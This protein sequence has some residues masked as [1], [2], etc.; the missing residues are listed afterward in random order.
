MTSRADML[1]TVLLISDVAVYSETLA[2]KINQPKPVFAAEEK[3]E[4]G[5]DEG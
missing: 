1:P 4:G 5:K 3:E 2:W